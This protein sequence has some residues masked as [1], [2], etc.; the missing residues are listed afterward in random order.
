VTAESMDLRLCEDLARKGSAGDRQAC[1]D[2]VEHLWQSWVE[3]VRTNRSMGPLADSEDHVH[4][5]VARLIDRLGQPGGGLRRYPS[6]RESHPDRTFADWMRI[7]TAN[8]VRDYVREQ[9]GPRRSSASGPSPKRLL[10]EF[11]LYCSVEELGVRPP[12]TLAQTARELMDFA[13][14]RLSPTQCRALELWLEGIE[15]GQIDQ[16]LGLAE[17]QARKLLRAGVATLRRHF[18]G[19]DDDPEGSA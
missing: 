16:E 9:L 19:A 14:S 4:N 5:V 2:L 8:L 12:I 3:M 15:F 18:G 7:V 6:W 10:N 1:H 13:R 11:T 17:G